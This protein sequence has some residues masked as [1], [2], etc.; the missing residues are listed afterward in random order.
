M[1]EAAGFA[2]VVSHRSGEAED[3][4]IAGLGASTAATQ[5]KTGSLC[6][7]D[8]M[9]KCNRLLLIDAE[10]GSA[11]RFAGRGAVCA[12]R[13]SQQR[14]APRGMCGPRPRSIES[15]LMTDSLRRRFDA[16]FKP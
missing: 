6:R 11:A 16:P 9:A 8:R 12:L 15:G 5:I 7:P 1:A 3:T 10:L 14:S 2:S 13:R 4:K